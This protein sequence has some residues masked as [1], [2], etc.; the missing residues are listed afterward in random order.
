[1]ESTS[2]GRP[3]RAGGRV[4]AGQVR[5]EAAT[6][7]VG[8]GVDVDGIRPDEVEQVG[9]VHAGRLEELLTEGAAELV[10]VPVEGPP[11]VL[12]D[13]AD[14]GVAVGVQAAAREAEDD[15]A[16]GD[17]LRPEDVGVLDDT[18]GRSRDV[19]LVGVEQARVLGRLP[20]DEGDP[21]LLA[22]SGDAGDDRCD[23]LGHDLPRGDV[24][25]HEERLGAAHDDVVD[26]HPD[27]V[28]PDGVM[29]VEGLGDGDLGADAV[30]ARGEHGAGHPG[31]R[32]RVE[33]AREP[34]E[35]AQDFR[36]RG[37]ADAGL[38]QLDGLVT[39]LDVDAGR[40]IRDGG[41]LRGARS[42][43]EAYRGEGP[44]WRPPAPS[45]PRVRKWLPGRP[46]PHSPRESRAV[47]GRG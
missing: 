16:R 31:D 37:S 40:G 12:D 21:G 10:D 32:A 26:D 11:R 7:D 18:R 46:L 36:P 19:V 30:G 5:C 9:G 39:G 33:H 45:S 24:V 1:M 42:R 23:A 43:R 35:P 44:E 27:E 14:E 6:G 15:V 25:G 47:R 4:D 28:E 2:S 41:R 17:A 34:A 3:S 38:H 22:G 13:P 8:E 29:P 20:A